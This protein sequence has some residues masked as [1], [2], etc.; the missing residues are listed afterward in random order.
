MLLLV[1]ARRIRE[2][3]HHSAFTKIAPTLGGRA[4]RSASGSTR[5]ETGTFQMRIFEAGGCSG[6]PARPAVNL[7]ALF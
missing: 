6:D 1:R 2:S 5:G 4:R 3:Q 7:E